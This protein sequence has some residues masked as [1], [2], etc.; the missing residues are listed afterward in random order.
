MA[1]SLYKAGKYKKALKLME[2]IVPAYRGK[3]QAERLTFIYANTYYQMGDF[4]LAGYQF[5]RFETSYPRSD[6]VE[7]AS[8]KSA[9]SY[10][11][12]SPRFSLDQEDTHT[13]LNKLQAFINTYPNTQYRAEANELV[14]ELRGKLELKDMRV[15]KQYLKIS[16]YKPAIAAFENFISDHPGSPFRK[17]AFFGRL[18]AGY[19]LAINSVPRLINERL[20]VAK[21]YYDSFVKYYEDTEL[22][23]DAEVILKD[24]NKRLNIEEPTS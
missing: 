1:D 3:P 10:Y 6:S 19:Q 8:F 23:A 11:E 4:Y 17:D 13:A 24:I 5:E 20:I 18:D 21:T 12:L 16:D 9:K 7:I 15:A 14:S 2:Q 22:M